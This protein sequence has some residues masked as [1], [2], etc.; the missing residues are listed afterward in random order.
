M[1]A[2]ELLEEEPSVQQEDYPKIE[3][4]TFSLLDEDQEENDPLQ[5]SLLEDNQDFSR[6]IN[7]DTKEKMEKDQNKLEWDNYFS[8]LRKKEEAQKDYASRSYL[9]KLWQNVS[10]LGARGLEAAGGIPADLKSFADFMLVDLPE[11]ALG[12]MPKYRQFI[13][14]NPKK[15]GQE[16]YEEYESIKGF[17]LPTSEEIKHKV[18]KPLTGEYTE[19]R[20]KDQK[21]YQDTIQDIVRFFAP[22]TSAN[23]FTRLSPASKVA[24]PIYANMGK[25]ISKDLGFSPSTQELV[26]MGLMLGMDLH[27]RSNTRGYAGY[28]I[29]EAERMVRPGQMMNARH[30]EH[31]LNQVEANLRRGGTDPS[32]TRAL[33]TIQ[34]VRDRIHNG[35]IET[36]DLMAFRRRLNSVIE[37]GGGY[38]VPGASR[39]AWTRNMQ[40]V[41][42]RI[43]GSVDRELRRTNPEAARLWREGNQA[44]SVFAQSNRMGNWMRRQAA[45]NP[46]ASQA[47]KLMMGPAAYHA[48]ESIMAALP[49]A[50]LAA[51]PT[52]GAI[53]AYQITTRAMRSPT[54]RQHYRN[55]MNAAARENSILFN[56]SMKK[57]D[58]ALI[59]EEAKDPLLDD[60]TKDQ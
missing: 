14:G 12:D 17:H 58:K 13:T 36:A 48:G 22:G 27:G 32:T 45:R 34:E 60:L 26:K 33:Q 2:F 41:K 8:D 6:P 7:E 3:N 44:F 31:R 1:S 23:R 15:P 25:E 10:G 46:I 54:I 40:R 49:K 11:K 24:I 29:N 57:L 38:D 20:S 39:P 16:G 43:I 4:S 55:V 50:A 42:N 5:S 51:V 52:Y 28:L 53:K 19:P 21:F 30:I 56:E 9:G 47:L 35:Q 59:E 37:S 18:T